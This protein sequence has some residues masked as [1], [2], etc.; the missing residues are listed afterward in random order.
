MDTSTASVQPELGLKFSRRFPELTRRGQRLQHICLDILSCIPDGG[1]RF[2]ESS[3]DA[4]MSGLSIGV[5]MSRFEPPTN[6]FAV[7][8]QVAS[9]AAIIATW[10]LTRGN[11]ATL[12]D[13]LTKKIATYGFEPF[14]LPQEAGEKSVTLRDKVLAAR[15]DKIQEVLESFPDEE[16]RVYILLA[17]WA[18]EPQAS[19]SKGVFITRG[20]FDEALRLA[21]PNIFP[22]VDVIDAA[23]NECR[24]LKWIG[25]NETRQHTTMV[26]L[27]VGG[28]VELRVKTALYFAA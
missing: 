14:S 16:P 7:R 23:I 15:V 27:L 20:R 21:T 2:V 4:K 19:F 25:T 6:T 8:F 13:E 12:R 18:L 28:I 22:T 9:G 26:Y 5:S 24:E 3:F 1:V 11:L 10:Q 17:L